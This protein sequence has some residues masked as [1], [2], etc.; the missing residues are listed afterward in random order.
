MLEQ[1]NTVLQEQMEG[2][3]ENTTSV[4]PQRKSALPSRYK[5]FIVNM[6]KLTRDD[7]SHRG[8]SQGLAVHTVKGHE[9]YSPEYVA[10]LHNVFLI[11]EPQSYEEAVKDEG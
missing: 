1:P 7:V 5:D 9:D 10:S 8:A 6:P 4:R 3:Q 2:I 11:K